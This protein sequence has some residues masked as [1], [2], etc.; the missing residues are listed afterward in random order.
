MYRE[1]TEMFR[2]ILKAIKRDRPDEWLNISQ[3]AQW[4]KL[5]P[6]TLRRYARLGA[7]KVSKKTG[8][9]LFQKSNLDR[10]LN[11]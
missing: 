9:L 4:V 5:S 6:Q 7:L 11:G 2:E 8:R 1:T 10:W 3:A